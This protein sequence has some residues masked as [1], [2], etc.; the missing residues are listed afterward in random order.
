MWELHGARHSSCLHWQLG[1][2]SRRFRCGDQI[3][4]SAI[5]IRIK[6]EQPPL[7]DH[8]PG[9]FQ[10][11][12]QFRSEACARRFRVSQ[13]CANRNIMPFGITQETIWGIAAPRGTK[14]GHMAVGIT[15][16]PVKFQT[17]NI[18]SRLCTHLVLISSSRPTGTS[19]LD[20][21]RHPVHIGIRKPCIPEQAVRSLVVSRA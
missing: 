11:R 4:G 19:F 10:A 2:S 18:G 3:V 12:R 16:Q 1:Q 15:G 5:A 21:G 13:N 14:K 7:G 8:P 20:R 6:S 9:V 17:R